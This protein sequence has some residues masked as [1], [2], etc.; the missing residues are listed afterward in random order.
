MDLIAA[1]ATAGISDRYP[2]PVKAIAV[3][4]VAS[5]RLRDRIDETSLQLMY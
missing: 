2:G 5:I 1:D 4:P 3:P